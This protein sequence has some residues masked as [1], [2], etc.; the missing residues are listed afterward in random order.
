[1]VNTC[2]P[3]TLSRLFQPRLQ[4]AGLLPVRLAVTPGGTDRNV[5]L[6]CC[7]LDIIIIKNKIKACKEKK[8]NFM[9][10]GRANFLQTRLCTNG[11][12]Q[13]SSAD[14]HWPPCI[15]TCHLFLFFCPSP[16]RGRLP[17]SFV[18]ESYGA[19]AGKLCL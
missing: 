6:L 11:F 13:I 15:F 1:M 8:L 3:V 10:E 7:D 2:N 18:F 9:E 12:D 4:V 5:S 17:G 16:T 14:K 19:R